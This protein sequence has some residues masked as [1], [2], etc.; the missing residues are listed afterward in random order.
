[1]RAG[2]AGEDGL[3]CGDAFRFVIDVEKVFEAC[4]GVV[5]TLVRGDVVRI[6]G[7]DNA[8]SARGVVQETAF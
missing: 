8:N 2:R 3:A 4:C 7:P 1:M 6:G 5:G